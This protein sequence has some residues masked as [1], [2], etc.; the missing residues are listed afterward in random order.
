M[1]AEVMS[2]RQVQVIGHCWWQMGGYVEPLI[3]SY[4]G[5]CS[6]AA[7][8]VIGALPVPVLM[9]CLWYLL[10]MHPN[11]ISLIVEEIDCNDGMVNQHL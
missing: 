6:A 3:G 9:P 5:R 10:V 2:R 8:V 1:A 11:T 4:T 7:N